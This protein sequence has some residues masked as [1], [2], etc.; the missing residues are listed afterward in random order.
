MTVGLAERFLED[1][2]TDTLGDAE[3]TILEMKD[4]VG[5]SKTI[6]VILSRGILRTGDRM[7]FA[8]SDGPATTRIKGLKRPRGMAEMR[9]AGDRWESVDHV[10]AA[11]GVK[12]VAQG[13]ERALAG[14]T[15]RLAKDEAALK[16]AIAACHEE[17]RVDIDLQEEGVVIKADTIGGLEALAFELG[18]LDIPIRMATV[19]PVNK[20]D[21]L[22]AE[23]AKDPLNRIIAGFSIAPNR[24]V[25]DRLTAEDA[26]IK[27][28]AGDI[29]YHIIDEIE[30]WRADTKAAAEA[31]RGDWS[32]PALA[33]PREPHLPWTRPRHIGVRVI[34]G[35]VHIGQRLMRPDG[36][37]VGQVK[38]L[39][40]RD[41]EDVR[42]ANQGDEVACAIQG[43]TV[44]RHINEGDEFLVDVP[45]SHARRLRK[46]ELTAV[47]EEILDEIVRLHR[48][49]N[50]FWA[51]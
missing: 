30:T 32:T 8:T 38:S 21:I 12:I 36:S 23:S 34:G 15:V 28:V 20:R 39:R 22:T 6:D 10:E 2:L 45:E 49:E 4:E 31:A 44:G 40:T 47:E 1:R 27:F 33:L 7:V 13:L 26:P 48:K 24:E 51:R 5:M 18:Q 25:A 46:V 16:A 3:G 17:C 37:Q 41:S 11:C 42:E 14:T 35:R 29:I 9:D 43:P 19:G 50:H